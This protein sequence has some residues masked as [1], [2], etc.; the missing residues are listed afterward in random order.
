MPP[1]FAPLR[2]VLLALRPEHHEHRQ[3]AD[4]AAHVD[5]SGELGEL[6]SHRRGVVHHLADDVR[7]SWVPVVGDVAVVALGDIAVHAVAADEAVDHHRAGAELALGDAVGDGVTDVVRR[8]RAHD[9]QV[10]E[11]V[12]RIHRVAVDLDVGD[13]APERLWPEEEGQ[14]QQCCKQHPLH[15]AHDYRHGLLL[16]QK[17]T[18]ALVLAMQDP[19][20]LPDMSVAALSGVQVAAE[21]ELTVPTVAPVGAPDTAI[22]SEVVLAPTVMTVEDPPIVPLP[23]LKYPLEP[24]ST[25]PTCMPLEHVPPVEPG[26]RTS[27]P[28]LPALSLMVQVMLTVCV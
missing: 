19:Q 5:G 6:V 17:R 10:A 24:R 3:P 11:V 2:L 4:Q 9:R 20:L 15:G 12:R 1:A 27:L 13:L 18:V 21:P 16:S 7:G 23:P 22:V 14:R 28:V 26:T 8:L 25:E